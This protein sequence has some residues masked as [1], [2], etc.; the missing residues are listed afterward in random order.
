MTPAET[1]LDDAERGAFDNWAELEAF[2]DG[3]PVRELDLPRATSQR[4]LP[5][6]TRQRLAEVAARLYGTVAAAA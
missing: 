4:Q 3:T 1:F 2:H 5:A 6:A